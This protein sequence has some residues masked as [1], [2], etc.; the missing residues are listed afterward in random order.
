MLRIGPWHFD[1]PVVQAALAGY[2]DAPMRLIARRLGAPYA[3]HQVVLDK[4]IAHSPK[5]RQRLLGTL[6]PEDHPVGG[7]LL[8]AEPGPLAEAASIL[9]E[10]GFDVID[11]NFGCPVRKVLGRCRGGHLLSDPPQAVAII[12]AVRRSVPPHIP[13]TVKMRRGTDDSAASEAKFWQIFDA[14][15]ELGVAALTVHGRTVAQKYMGQASWGFLATL[16]RRAGGRTII[17]SGDLYQAEDIRRMLETTGVDGV[18]LARGCIGNPWLFRDAR[19]A[20]AGEPLPEPPSVAEQG[21]VIREHLALSVDAHGPRIAGRMI[22]KDGIQ[23]AE[24]HPQTGAVRRAFIAAMSYEQVVGV[25]D[26]WYD[27]TRDWPPGMRRTNR[28]PRIAA[29]APHA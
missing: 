3:L 8:G 4:C 27:P 1:L 20:L 26:S 10:R 28:P 29:S 17:G 2:S 13:V 5:T 11:L 7:Q 6:S 12:R 19:A 25:L 14:A 21:A 16:K 9:V 22:R 15:M 18:S 23:Y 24:A